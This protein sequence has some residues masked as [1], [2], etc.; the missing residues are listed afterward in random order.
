[1][2]VRVHRAIVR[3]RFDELDDDAR[4]RLVA[5]LDRHA[6]LPGGF[7]PEGTFSYDARLD[8]FSLRYEIRTTD[9]EDPEDVAEARALDDLRRSGLPHGPLTVR[10]TDMAS[11]W[12]GRRGALR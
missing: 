10:A 9:D 1:M 11:I 12:D 6:G 7:T 5:D 4:A 3:G 2:A 8:F